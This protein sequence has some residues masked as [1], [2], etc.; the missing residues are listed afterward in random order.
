MGKNKRHRYKSSEKFL[1]E[2]FQTS[3]GLIQINSKMIC[4]RLASSLTFKLSS[5]SLKS[6]TASS[7]GCKADFFTDQTLY[8]AVAPST[9][10][11]KPLSAY[12]LFAQ[13]ER[14]NVTRLYPSMKLGQVSKEV[15]KRYKSLSE[16]QKQPYVELSQKNSASYKEEMAAF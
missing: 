6:G 8:N 5:L 16:R 14:P 10:P 7:V 12:F 2:N 9:V 11:K 1:T 15:S 4:G 3:R 13:D